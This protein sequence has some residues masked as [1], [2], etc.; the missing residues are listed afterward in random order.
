M[1]KDY[2]LTKE[3]QGAVHLLCTKLEGPNAGISY[4]QHEEEVYV[5]VPYQSGASHHETG[6][7]PVRRCSEEKANTLKAALES[8]HGTPIFAQSTP[9]EAKSDYFA[10]MKVAKLI[11]SSKLEMI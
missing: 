9:V 10:D 2:V 4:D 1:S 7:K 11:I 8:C 6:A 5:W 3:F